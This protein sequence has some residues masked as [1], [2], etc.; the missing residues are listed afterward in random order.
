MNVLSTVTLSMTILYMYL[1]HVK[2]LDQFHQRCLQKVLNIKWFD[3]ISNEQVLQQ[4]KM[5]SIDSLLTKAQLRWT[6]H[7]VRME[8][9]R[10]P[11]QIFYSELSEGQPP[12]G[13]PRLRCKDTLKKGH[14]R[15]ATNQWTSGRTWPTIDLLGVRPLTRLWN[16]LNTREEAG[17]WQRE[18]QGRPEQNTHSTLSLAPTVAACVPPNSASDPIGAYTYAR[19]DFIEYD[20]RPYIFIAQIY[21]IFIYLT[22]LLYSI[23]IIYLILFNSII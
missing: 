5:P 3:R 6:G 19:I 8:D 23:Y 11:K 21:F 10:L 2:L 9:T 13:R 18:R 4:T 17:K 12:R 22:I 14:L 16:R 15:N 20:G 1:L 7:I